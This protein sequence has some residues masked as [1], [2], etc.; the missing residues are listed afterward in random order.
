MCSQHKIFVIHLCA[1]CVSSNAGVAQKDAVRCQKNS[2]AETSHHFLSENWCIQQYP[3]KN[4]EQYIQAS[5]L[6]HRQLL[7]ARYGW[8]TAENGAGLQFVG[9]GKS[10]CRCLERQGKW[11]KYRALRH[12]L[13]EPGER[14]AARRLGQAWAGQGQP[15]PSSVPCFSMNSHWSIPSALPGLRSPGAV[16]A[17]WRCNPNSQ[18]TLLSGC[19]GQEWKA[20][21][22]EKAR[23]YFSLKKSIL[24]H[25]GYIF[26][27]CC[28]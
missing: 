15:S 3:A 27:C 14:S 19:L 23:V 11:G 8:S 28:S 6:T 13:P 12:S 10:C 18:T 26:A 4:L 9:A 7:V 25:F 1:E 16:H 17:T 21:S 24:V 2:K 22:K 20:N 5:L